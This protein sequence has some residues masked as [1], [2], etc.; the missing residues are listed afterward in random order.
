MRN[1]T[2]KVVRGSD[3]FERKKEIKRLWTRIRN[4]NNILLSAPRRVGKTSIL[5]YMEDNPQW[6]C[7]FLYVIVQSAE[8][9]HDYY[10]RILEAFRS[11]EFIGNWEKLGNQFKNL[12]DTIAARVEGVELFEA[13][14]RFKDPNRRLTHVDLENVLENLELQQTLVLVIDEYPDVVDT[15]LR[16]QGEDT[17]IQFLKGSRTLRQNSKIGEKVQF[18]YTGSIGL[19]N[20]MQKINASGLINDLTEMTIKPMA[21][22]ESVRFVEQLLNGADL[23]FELSSAGIRH[24]LHRLEWLM[25]YYVQLLFQE[26]TDHCIENDLTH[27]T[28]SDI[29]QAFDNLFLA[30]K[31]KN[32]SHWDERLRKFNTLEQSFIR[33]CLN[34]MSQNPNGELPRSATFNLS[35]K[36]KYLDRIQQA[37]LVNCL[38]HDGY[39]HE[40][41]NEPIVY[42]FNSP[43]LRE[44]WKRY[45]ATH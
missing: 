41:Q 33:D 12:W 10:T 39:I 25:P 8:T 42:R 35:Q 45:V 43:L 3:F 38:V 1:N 34:L 24:L 14:V 18:V 11:S 6:D 29:D 4:G 15:L 28:H 21:H 30:G 19:V 5:R 17:A 32:F 16:C 20:L 27:P 22:A 26:L 7:V 9:E 36:P 44:W 23:E 31:T 37:Y 2:G 13:G 40:S